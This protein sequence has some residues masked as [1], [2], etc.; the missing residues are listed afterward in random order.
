MPANGFRI[1]NRR[2]L[3]TYA[4]VGLDFDW[5][6][7]VRKL[8][9]LGFHS[10]IARELHADG[11]I[12]FHVYADHGTPFSTRCART[13]DVGGAHPNIEPIRRSPHTVF[14]YV[15]KDGD[16]VHDDIPVGQRPV[17]GGTAKRSRDDVWTE[18]ISAPDKDAFFEACKTLAPRELICC[19]TQC[20]AFADWN[21]RPRRERYSDPRGLLC[22]TSAYPDLDRWVSDSIGMGSNGRYEP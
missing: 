8:H 1:N 22:D 16:V 21:Y 5:Q 20:S 13:F 2:I 17:D 15:G 6:G 10:R 7:I 4:Q 11:G 19:F 9:E 12:H 3:L 18:I 14:E